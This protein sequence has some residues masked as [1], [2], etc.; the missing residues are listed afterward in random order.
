[1]KNFV[2]FLSKKFLTFNIQNF[3]R[4]VSDFFL[5]SKQFHPSSDLRKYKHPGIILQSKPIHS[6]EKLDCLLLLQQGS[7]R[8]GCL[9]LFTSSLQQLMDIYLALHTIFIMK[10]FLSNIVYSVVF[11]FWSSLVVQLIKDT[12]LSLQWLRSLLGMDSVPGQ[13]LPHPMVVAKKKVFI[14]FSVMRNKKPMMWKE[15]HLIKI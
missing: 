6:P 13:E 9:I 14:F 12:V 1:M 3:F 11:V 5:C 7:R 10:G 8:R 15:Q 4:E 2:I